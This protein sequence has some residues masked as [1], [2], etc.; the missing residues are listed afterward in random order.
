MIQKLEIKNFKSVKH[1]TLA[2]KRINI[3]IGEPN[4]GKSN[5]LETLGMFSFVAYGPNNPNGFR[6]YIRFDRTGNI[7]YDEILDE[8]V[9]IMLDNDALKIGF[10]D[11]RF[12]GV[13]AQGERQ[14]ARIVGGHDGL[15][16]EQIA[17][18]EPFS[19]VKFYRFDEK[20][21]TFERQEAEFLLPPCGKNLMSLLLGHRDLRRMAN[22]I[23]GKYGLKVN[24]RP[25]ENTVE[26]MKQAED[27]TVTYPYSLA[28]DT[29]KRIV[30]HLTAILSN[31]DSI[32]VFEEPESHA[33]PYYTKQLAETIALDEKN[34]Q[35]FVSTHNPYFLLPL[36]EKAP[37]QDVAIFVTYYQDHQTKCKPLSEAEMQQVT[38]IDI[39]SN[40]DRF[41]ETR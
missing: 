8:T 39:F 29:L 16:V 14:W 35:Y 24:V 41:L 22:D 25:Q 31:K 20:V 3:F 37:K 9:E 21:A 26:I 4:T 5:I 1:Q 12:T 36:V 2:C 18:R 30:F 28:S 10:K 17:N 27:I 34:N 23:F 40:L 7:F 13:F 15:V 32:L 6:D 33:F 38:E 19:R 11:G